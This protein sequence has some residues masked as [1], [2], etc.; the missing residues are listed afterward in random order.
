MPVKE[1]EVGT[2]MMALKDLLARIER[3]TGPD[4]ELDD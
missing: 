2:K 3:A 4:P 1:R